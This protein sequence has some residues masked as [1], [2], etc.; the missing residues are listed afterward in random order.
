M[1]PWFSKHAWSI[2]SGSQGLL[3]RSSFG[4]YDPMS[5]MGLLNQHTTP[6]YAE[7]VVLQSPNVSTMDKIELVQAIARADRRSPS[8]PGGS[9]RLRDLLPA[10]AGAGLGY[11]GASMVAPL[12]GLDPKTKKTLGIGAAALGAV[13]N[14]IPQ[15]LYKTSGTKQALLGYFGDR[16]VEGALDD[17]QRTGTFATSQNRVRNWLKQ[18]YLANP[19]NQ[20]YVRHALMRRLQN[21]E[22]LTRAFQNP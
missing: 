1:H 16:A 13:V 5:A 10:L 21:P 19:R 6:A 7:R 3:S 14:S 4:P 12:F 20:E 18:R 2:P 15:L 22:F 17:F 9:M 8:G 11:V